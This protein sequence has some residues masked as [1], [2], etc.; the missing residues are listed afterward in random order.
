MK[1]IHFVSSQ[2]PILIGKSRALSTEEIMSNDMQKL[3]AAMLNFA[4]G[5]QADVQR[6]VLVGLAAPQIGHA[7]RVILVDIKANGKGGCAELR[8]YI[9]PEIIA[10]SPEQATWYEGCYST[11]DVKG[12]VSRPN[13]VTIRALNREGVFVQEMHAGYVAR[14]FQH[15]IDHLDGIR[16]PERMSEDQE[17][18]LVKSPEMPLYRNDQGWKNWPT[19]APLNRWKEFI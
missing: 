2:D 10:A 3:F 11:G 16:F 1:A 4:R 9:N 19:T 13:Q 17:I 18:H 5:E 6:H 12:I 8:L 14:I 7:I 15:E